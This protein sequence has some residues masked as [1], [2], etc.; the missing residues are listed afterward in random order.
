M[1]DDS[2]SMSRSRSTCCQS[3]RRDAIDECRRRIEQRAECVAGDRHVAPIR[4][5]RSRQPLDERRLA[6][7]ERRS[8]EA[9]GD[10]THP[11]I[12]IGADRGGDHERVV[13]RDDRADRRDPARMKIW[14]RARL[15]HALMAIRRTDGRE[16]EQLLNGL[17]LERERIGQQDGR[18]RQFIAQVIDAGVIVDMDALPLQGLFKRGRVDIAAGNEKVRRDLRPSGGRGYIPAAASRKERGS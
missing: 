14:R 10:E 17:L 9:R 8:L 18:L 13:G 4:E 11:A 1:H 12:D 2:S 3:L 15:A 6:R 5:N 16:R 7:R